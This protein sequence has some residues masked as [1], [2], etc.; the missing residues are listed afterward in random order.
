MEKL[1]KTIEDKL[2]EGRSYRNMQSFE[3]REDVPD[4]KIARGYATT[5]N[6]PYELFSWD[7]WEGV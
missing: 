2:K 4:R 5:F 7:N 6:E 1:N 3:I